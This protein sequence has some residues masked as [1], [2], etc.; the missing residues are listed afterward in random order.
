[1]SVHF[2]D[3]HDRL[4]PA[5]H[6]NLDVH[7]CDA[8]TASDP[9]SIDARRSRSPDYR[10]EIAEPGSYALLATGVDAIAFAGFSW[11]RCSGAQIE[12]AGD[13]R[14]GAA[15]IGD[16]DDA[17]YATG[18]DGALWVWPLREPQGLYSLPLLCHTAFE[19]RA[20]VAVSRDRLL[21]VITMVDRGRRRPTPLTRAYVA[22]LR[23]SGPPREGRATGVVTRRVLC[24]EHDTEHAC[25]DDDRV[26]LAGR[27]FVLE[28]DTSGAVRWIREGVFT[29]GGVEVIGA[30]VGLIVTGPEPRLLILDRGGA[31]SAAIAVSPSARFIGRQ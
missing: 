27:D 4:I 7:G 11:M 18:Y 25:N 28:L 13:C 9:A 3:A 8:M 23:A 19:Q 21:D 14:P 29:V 2:Y 16:H 24:G 17:L 22:D 20:L 26:I 31:P 1:M 12:A 5:G 15:T 6:L 10:M 30:H